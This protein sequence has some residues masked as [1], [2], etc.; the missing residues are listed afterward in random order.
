VAR[1]DGA[2]GSG[3]CGG[4]C[5]GTR[6]EIKRKKVSTIERERKREREREGELESWRKSI[7][8]DASVRFR[9]CCSNTYLY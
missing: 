5:P 4:K 8:C 7:D 9:E 2:N 6:G 1:E 3:G